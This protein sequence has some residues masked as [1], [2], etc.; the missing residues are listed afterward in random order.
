M[1]L[2]S[3]SNTRF[4][5]EVAPEHAPA[6]VQV[7][8]GVPIGKLGTVTDSADLQITQ[9]HHPVVVV[10]LDRLKAAWQAPLN[11]K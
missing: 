9:G 2:F 1:L 7:L 8:A 11:W 5:C 3:E 10:G 6:F 4:L